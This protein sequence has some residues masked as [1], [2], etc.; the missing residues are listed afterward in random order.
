[1]MIDPGKPWKDGNGISGKFL[2]ENVVR[3]IS[4]PDTVSMGITPRGWG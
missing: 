1:M 2:N 4:S 3:D